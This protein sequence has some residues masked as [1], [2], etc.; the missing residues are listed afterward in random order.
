MDGEGR[1]GCVED[2][3]GLDGVE[4]RSCVDVCLRE[5]K[6]E[7]APENELALAKLAVLDCGGVSSLSASG[8]G[9]GVE[10]AASSSGWAI[11]YAAST[12][13]IHLPS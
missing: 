1:Y 8:V 5:G 2:D 12:V 13:S 6:G 11:A 10:M 7:G 3:G 9:L 4:L